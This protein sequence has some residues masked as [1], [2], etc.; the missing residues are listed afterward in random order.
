MDLFSIAQWLQATA[1]GTALRESSYAYPIVM[2]THLSGM[3]LFGGMILMVDMRLLGLALKG[4][5][6]T[7]IVEG[8]RPWK[9]VGFLLT[10]TCGFLLFGSEA[11]KYYPNPYF[12]LKMIILTLIAIHALVFRPSVYNNTAE[13]DRLP[14]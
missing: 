12:R 6:V 8:L 2:T 4:Q 5:S 1:W 14:A 3:A 9:R 11:E 7:S 10:A 13:I